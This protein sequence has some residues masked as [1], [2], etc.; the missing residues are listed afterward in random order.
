LGLAIVLFALTGAAVSRNRRAH[1]ETGVPGNVITAFGT[2][3]GVDG[4][5]VGAANP[6][7]GVIGD[8]LPWTVDGS[9]SGILTT[10]GHLRIRVRGLVFTDDPEVPPEL[11]GKNDETQFRGMVS[12]TSEDATGALVTANVATAGFPATPSGDSDIDAL[13]TLPSPCV[14]PIVLVLAGSEDK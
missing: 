10:D 4:G 7:R 5:L 13:I 1:Q 11:R 9:A 6:I 2:M 8:E 12:C 3:Y 14:A